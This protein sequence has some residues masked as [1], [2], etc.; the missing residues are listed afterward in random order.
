MKKLIKRW[1]KKP[2]PVMRVLPK[3]IICIE[4]SG[5]QGQIRE[6]RWIGYVTKSWKTG[7]YS[8]TT[9]FYEVQ[10]L[11]GKYFSEHRDNPLPKE[12]A[13]QIQ[14]LGMNLYTFYI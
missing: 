3:I 6:F 1:L 9:D 11:I 5:C 8:N 7:E 4:C 12:T 2:L 14:Y 13:W 10:P